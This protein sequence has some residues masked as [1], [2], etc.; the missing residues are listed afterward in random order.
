MDYINI[1]PGPCDE[2]CAQTGTYDYHDRA[3]KECRR[4]IELI[5]KVLGP[6]PANTRL[7]IKTFMHDFG[8]YHEVVCHY[9]PDD[10][11]S[12]EYAFKCEGEAPTKWEET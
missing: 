5:R 1:G 8:N 12:V 6:E 7:G 9:D 2:D 11:V 10:S 3:G 4:F